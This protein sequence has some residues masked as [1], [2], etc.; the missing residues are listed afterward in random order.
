MVSLYEA[1]NLLATIRAH[2]GDAQISETDVRMF[3]AEL[4]PSLTVDEARRA[5]VEY[6]S[7]ARDRWCGAGDINA[8]V[9]ARRA[10]LRPSEA[11]IGRE[12]EERG[13]TEDQTWLYRRQRLSGVQPEEAA[14][15]ALSARDPL[16]LPPAKPKPK[17]AGGFN[18]RLGVGLGQV[19]TGGR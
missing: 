13:L 11:Q 16:Q 1:S 5:I 18:P 7:T 8:I 2:H 15:R 6:Y 4:L 17:R 9:K 19:I 10:K 14:S 3:L 12:A